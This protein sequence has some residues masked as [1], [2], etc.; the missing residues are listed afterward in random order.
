MR[1][2]VIRSAHTPS[3]D[4]VRDLCSLGLTLEQVQVIINEINQNG[5]VLEQM[6]VHPLVR[7]LIASVQT[8][9]W[10]TL[11]AIIHIGARVVVNNP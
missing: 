4:R 7:N 11:E 10:F 2:I 9:T 5:S 6:H 3:A 1:E 8:S